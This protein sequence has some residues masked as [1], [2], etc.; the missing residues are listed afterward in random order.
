MNGST[1][2][3]LTAALVLLLSGCYN[4]SG[5]GS[6]PSPLAAGDYRLAFALPAQTGSTTAVNG[7]DL[8]VA[9]PAGVTVATVDAGT[10]Q[11]ADA[12]MAAGPALTG[13]SLMAG[14]FAASQAHVSLTTAA[15]AAW[16]GDFLRLTV[17]IPAGVKVTEAGLLKTVSAGLAASTVVG[18]ASTS[19]DTVTLTG[20]LAPTVSLV[21]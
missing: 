19:H 14:R 18:L 4:S 3:T 6:G 1:M 13:T 16:S 10:G 15:S 5:S 2:K 20:T 17:T 21:Q 8:T 11:I 9:L 12:S 7:V